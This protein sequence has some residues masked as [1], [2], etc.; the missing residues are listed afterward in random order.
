MLLSTVIGNV[1]SYAKWIH[2]RTRVRHM[3]RIGWRILWEVADEKR[4]EITK[5]Y[6][7]WVKKLLKDID[8]T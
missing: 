1:T 2:G 5:V 7:A 3:A 6:N 8:L 4:G